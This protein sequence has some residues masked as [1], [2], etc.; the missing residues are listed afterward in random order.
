MLFDYHEKPSNLSMIVMITGASR[1][2]G[3]DTALSLAASPDNTILAL[4]RDAKKLCALAA[5]AKEM[6][7][8]DNI[9]TLPFDITQPDE[10]AF[11]D[12]IDQAGGLDVLIN[13]A[14]Y[15]VN[16]PFEDMEPE[17]WQM[18]YESNVLGPAWLIKLSLPYLRKSK[19]PHVLNIG[20]MG[21]FQGS[22][23]FPGLSVYSS[24]K[25]AIANL[26]EC[27]AEEYKADGIVF[28]CLSLGSVQT[29]MLAE[30][31]PGYRAPLTSE[32]MGGFIS[33]FAREGGRFFNG[34]ILPVSVSTP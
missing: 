6:H 12:L 28:N 5:K 17:D 18:A 2:I 11:T 24:S 19:T 27:L 30:A 7:G 1:G 29:E 14:G 26:T 31:F 4:S 21:G 16:K 13:N 23:K 20:S 22:S 15:L 3:F 33:W 8:H 10:S 25:A 32:E 9:R 34:K